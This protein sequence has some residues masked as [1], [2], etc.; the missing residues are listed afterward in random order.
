MTTIFLIRHAEFDLLGK[1]LCGRT[2]GI[3]LNETGR[4]QARRLA[5]RLS[6]FPLDAIVCSPLDRACETAQPLAAITGLEVRKSPNLNEIAFGNWTGLSFDELK[7][8]PDW[9]DFNSCRS[10]N[11]APGGESLI[12]VQSRAVG[13]INKIAAGFPEGNIAVISHGDVIRTAIAYYLGAPLDFLSRFEISPASVS[14]LNIHSRG[15]LL[16][17]LNVTEELPGRQI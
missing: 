17:A 14:I 10:C 9:N 16:L 13:E 12:E 15:P 2:G 1:T 7:G 4:Q 6:R 8:L 3:S 5:M 11:R